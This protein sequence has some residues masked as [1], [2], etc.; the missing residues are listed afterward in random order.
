VDGQ[1][2]GTPFLGTEK[3]NGM[4]EEKR[5]KLSKTVNRSE[6]KPA[7]NDNDEDKQNSDA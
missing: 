3:E 4:L 2:K 1:K 5:F 6:C 7:S